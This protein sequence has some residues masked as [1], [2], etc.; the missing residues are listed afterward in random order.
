MSILVVDDSE[1]NRKL[2]KVNLEADGLN[3]VEAADGLEALECLNQNQI[4]LI[5]S[6]ILMPRMDGYRLCYEVRKNQQ[7][8][9]IPFIIYSSSYTSSD[10]EKLALNCG[11][12]R[13]IKKPSSM[14]TIF[15]TIQE[16]T[17]QAT[18]SPHKK[19]ELESE[20]EIMR[21]YSERLVIKLEERT[22]E[23]EQARDVLAKSEER[24]RDLF[25]NANDIIYTLDLAGNFTS[26]NK[27]GEQLTGYLREEILQMNF[28]A[29]VASN[30]IE[31]AQKSIKE[32]LASSPE[33]TV[34][35]LEIICKNR[36]RLPLEI[37]SRT[38]Y[39]AGKVAGIQGIARDISER[40]YL[41]DQLRQS[42]KMESIGRLAGGI[43]HD[44]NNLLT[45]I[46]GYSQMA[47]RQLKLD[48][49]VQKDIIE[50]E[51]AGNRAAELTGQLLA[52]SR[53][54]VVQPKILD[55]N[56]VV[57]DIKKMLGRLIGENIELSTNLSANPGKVEAEPGQI[58]QIIMNL[59]VNARDAMPEAGTLT[60]ETANIELDEKDTQ[61]YPHMKPGPY[62]ILAFSDTGTGMDKEIQSR[63]FEPFFTTKEMGKGTGL[64]LS[65]VY[66]IVKQSGGN[67]RLHSEPDKGTT[68]KIYLPR[69]EKI[70]QEKQPPPPAVESFAGAEI[71]LLV[72]DEDIIR[73]LTRKI[74]EMNGYTVLEADN[75]TNALQKFDE[76]SDKIDLIITD[77]VM[78]VMS[79]RELVQQLAK[80]GNKAKVLY[81]SGY[82]NNMLGNQEI[83]EA[84]TPFLQK[85][86]S[87]AAL[88]RK[89][90]ELLNA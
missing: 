25:E 22:I 49:P 86:F 6:D 4:D 45:A 11:A 54:Q 84:G 71:I 75:P 74:L 40:Q 46:I 19:L 52:F 17:T 89:I 78:P 9:A 7:F 12:D 37:S 69:V 50:I 81:M 36:S 47:M 10:D 34:Y 77:V 27:K 82:T 90:R 13:F 53:K 41:E 64:G 42:Q 73:Q 31:T 14:K 85:P 24:Y 30:F 20:S 57:S 60:I 18:L 48:D 38:M 28:S 1:L 51:K 68:F 43:A 80:K 35:K 63:I 5:I 88:L 59:A 29:L 23:L 15:E 70:S 87:P 55:L 56:Q 72:E 26:I 58:E 21:E 8:K 61:T 39:E 44:F 2:L 65:T 67:I 79:G 16:V 83:L 3:I 32:K 62:V 66:G 76:N 33:T